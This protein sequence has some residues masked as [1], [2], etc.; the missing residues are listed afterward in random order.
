M[1]DNRTLIS[2]IC[3]AVTGLAGLAS[4]ASGFPFNK[5]TPLWFRIGIFVLHGL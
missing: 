1:D 3:F 2:L 5:G 4:I